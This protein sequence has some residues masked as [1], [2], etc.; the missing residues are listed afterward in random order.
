MIVLCILRDHG[1]HHK[2][3]IASSAPLSQG[4]LLHWED[5]FFHHV[6]LQHYREDPVNSLYA[7]FST[8]LGWYQSGF[9]LHPLGI[10]IV[11]SFT[12]HYGIFFPSIISLIIC[13]WLCA[14][15]GN[16][17]R[18]AFQ[19]FALFLTTS[20]ISYHS[21]PSSLSWLDGLVIYIIALWDF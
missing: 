6:L 13:H 15:L 11:L 9:L 20:K 16:T 14:D 2:S 1:V 19:F 4:L 7:V 18:A 21:G 17:F 3:V 8:V 10:K 12:S 5:V